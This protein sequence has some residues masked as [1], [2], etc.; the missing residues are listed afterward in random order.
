[1]TN[2]LTLSMDSV[3]I[4]KAHRISKCRHTTISAMV[5]NFINSLEE[6][7]SGISDSSRELAP[8]TKKILEMGRKFSDTP[9]DWDYRDELSQT[10]S[11]KYGVDS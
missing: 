6:E 4:E 1:M 10:I 5:A 11:D 9:A 7:P 2:K 8:I 3:V